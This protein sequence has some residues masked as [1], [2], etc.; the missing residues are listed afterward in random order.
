LGLLLWKFK[1]LAV[2]VLTK[3]K[4]LLL[5]LTKASTLFSML[6]SFGVYWT[7]WGWKFALGLVASIYVHEMGHVAA[8]RHYGIKATAPMFIP[9]LGAIVRLRQ[10][11]ANPR[12]DARVG[13]AGPVWGLGA[14]LVSYAV[15]LGTGEPFWAATARVGAWINLFNLLPIWQ[16]DGGRGFRALT[17]AQRWVVV[18]AI[19]V[20]LLLT[21]EGLLILLLLVAGFRA[22]RPDRVKE[23]DRFT[24]LQF[25]LLI[26]ALS[27]LCKLPVPTGTTP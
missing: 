26:V 3:A 17:A 23:P 20:M 21:S 18:V 12:E 25:T 2:F 15:F 10:Y 16:L 13:L 27:L 24:L 11:P 19:A 7:V 4:L 6:L 22:L 14:A 5:G 1:F 9:G 8:L